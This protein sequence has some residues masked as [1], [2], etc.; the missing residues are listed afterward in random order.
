MKFVVSAVLVTEKYPAWEWTFHAIFINTNLSR[1]ACGSVVGWGTMLQTRR[2]WVR[3]PMRWIFFNWP[4][5]SGRTMALGVDSA[6]NRNEYQEDSWG[7]KHGRHI[8][9][10]TLPPSVSRLPRRCGRLDLSHPYGSSQPVT[11]AQLYFY[12]YFYF[13]NLSHPP[14]CSTMNHSPV[15]A[16]IFQAKLTIWCDSHGCGVICLYAIIFWEKYILKISVLYSTLFFIR[17]VKKIIP[18]SMVK[19]SQCVFFFFCKIITPI[20]DISN[21]KTW[22]SLH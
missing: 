9:L 22:I 6:S 12:F 21:L 5:P 16:N 19:I 18:Y 3:V 1:G 15:Q 2:S 13:T 7:V 4:N 10:T 20:A 11:G 17:T 8:R 14:N